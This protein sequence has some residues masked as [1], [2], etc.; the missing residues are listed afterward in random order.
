MFVFRRPSD[1]MG[2]ID[3]PYSSAADEEEE[4]FASNEGSE[5]VTSNG[6]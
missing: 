1:A 2:D 3:G 4:V 5:E 6:T